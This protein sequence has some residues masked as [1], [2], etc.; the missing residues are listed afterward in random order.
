MTEQKEKKVLI[1]NCMFSGYWQYFLFTIQTYDADTHYISMS[2]ENI[3]TSFKDQILLT[4]F[5]FN[6]WLVYYNKN[7]IQSKIL[8]TD[9]LIFL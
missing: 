2:K 6:I 5:K 8:T 4:L 9:F 1:Y 7:P 3:Y